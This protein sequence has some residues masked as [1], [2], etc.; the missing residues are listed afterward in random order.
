MMIRVHQLINQGAAAALNLKV[1]FAMLF[2][3]GKGLTCGIHEARSE[4]ADAAD[5]H[6][7]NLHQDCMS[8]TE[9]NIS[10]TRID[11]FSLRNTHT[12]QIPGT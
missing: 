12:R 8:G 4:G 5:G 3:F 11:I 1:S 9:A 2:H 7:T 6:K 10:R